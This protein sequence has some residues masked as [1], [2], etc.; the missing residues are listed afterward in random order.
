MFA[1]SRK[2]SLSE[3]RLAIPHQHVLVSCLHGER[4]VFL[5]EPRKLGFQVTNT[6]LEAAHLGDHAR[7]GTANVAE[8]SLRHDVKVLHAE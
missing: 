5:L 2:R 3:R 6:L 7:V 1:S 4:V 8:K